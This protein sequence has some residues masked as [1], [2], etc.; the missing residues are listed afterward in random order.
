M[1]CRCCLD[2]ASH[3]ASLSPPTT[4]FHTY[5]I[6][7]PNLYLQTYRNTKKC[8]HPPLPCI[9]THTHTTHILMYTHAF[10]HTSHSTQPTHTLTITHTHPNTHVRSS[11]LVNTPRTVLPLYQVQHGP[12]DEAFVAYVLHE[13]LV[14][15][16][17]LHSENR[18]HR[19]IK[20]A[21]ILLGPTGKR[22]RSPL[23][24]ERVHYSVQRS[25]DRILR[26]SR[27]QLCC[28]AIA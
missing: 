20:A 12:L 22:K 1:N 17:Y 13:V 23:R 26:E 6:N 11:D 14:A 19:D 27:R 25:K 10:S 3:M 16:A 5:V 21:N 9:H 8:A 4:C 24:F 7:A 15:L 18:I 28:R 2:V